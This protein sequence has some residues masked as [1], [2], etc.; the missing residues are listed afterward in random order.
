MRVREI[1]GDTQSAEIQQ[2]RR[3]FNSLLRIIENVATLA[4]ATT[5]TDLQAWE[6]IQDA[7][8]TGL[9]SDNSPY[10]GTGQELVGVRVTP[11]ALRKA[12]ANA[13]VVEDDLTDA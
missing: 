8:A 4:T 2:M 7:I 11:T 9:D 1:V 3:S 12:Q 13:R 10:V 6:A 5:I